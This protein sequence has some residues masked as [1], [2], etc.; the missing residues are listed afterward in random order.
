MTTNKGLNNILDALSR[1]KYQSY[2]HIQLRA[3]VK[4]NCDNTKKPRHTSLFKELI[5]HIKTVLSSNSKSKNKTAPNTINNKLCQGKTILGHQPRKITIQHNAH[6]TVVKT[7]GTVPAFKNILTNDMTQIALSKNRSDF[8]SQIFF[9][10]INSELDVFTDKEMVNYIKD[11][12]YKV[13]E[14]FYAGNIYKRLDYSPKDFK[15]SELDNIFANN[16]SVPLR[17]LRVYGDVFG[18]NIVYINPESQFT[19]LTFYDKEKATVVITED[20]YSIYTVRNKVD[21]FIR[22]K[23]FYTYLY[24]KN[25]PGLD[26]LEKFNIVNLQNICKLRSV[27][28]KKKGKT[29]RVNKTKKELISEL[30]K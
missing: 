25:N 17:M 2:E 14:A 11:I 5:G 8:Y 24:N 6:K 21:C 22:G 23:E 29:K 3:K 16:L 15:K 26:S 1:I 7:P 12:K 27:V 30:F 13:T 9:Q 10:A 20:N 4:L 28:Y 18:A 19:F